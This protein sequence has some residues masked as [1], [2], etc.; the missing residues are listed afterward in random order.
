MPHGLICGPVSAAKAV[1]VETRRAAR[2]RRRFIEISRRKEKR[3]GV[4]S[5]ALS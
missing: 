3:R 1:L 5:A 2:S 4:S